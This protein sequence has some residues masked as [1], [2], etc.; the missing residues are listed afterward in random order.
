MKTRI[1]GVLFAGLLTASMDAQAS[2]IFDIN[3]NGLDLS[4]S[5]TTNLVSGS[6]LSIRWTVSGTDDAFLLIDATS[7]RSSGVDIQAMG[8]TLIDGNVLFHDGLR[9]TT[10]DGNTVVT[11]SG[12]QM[13]GIFD[14]QKDGMIN[15]SDAA[16]NMLKVFTDS[17][18]DGMMGTGEILF[19]NDS[20]VSA[21]SLSGL[22]S[23]VTDMFGN[24][25]VD[26]T[27]NHLTGSTGLVA[28]VNFAAVGDITQPVTE[29]STILLFGTGLAGLGLLRKRFKS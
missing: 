26:G 13:L 23:M 22:S 25:R 6:P 12:W 20:N 7:L 8:G 28:D 19:L 1:L 4:G 21:I 3:G 29:P 17:N 14:L 5:T 24:T 18:A 10:P 15:S 9:V 2:L 16:W 11:N 27:Y